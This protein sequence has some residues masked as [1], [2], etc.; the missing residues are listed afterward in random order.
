M[1]SANALRQNPRAQAEYLATSPEEG[2]VLFQVWGAEAEALGL[3]AALVE[4]HGAAAVDLNCGCPVRKVRAAGAGSRLL[5][6]PPL[7]GQLVREMRRR[8]RLP[9][10]V[11]IRLGPGPGRLNAVEVARVAE[12]EGVDWL[13]LHG[14]HAGESYGAPCRYDEIAKVVAAVRVPVVGNGDVRDG[15]SAQRMFATGVAGV[16]L[17][18]A[19]MGAP[20]VF[21]KVRAECAGERF[22]PPDLPAIGRIIMEHH[23]LLA[24]LLGSERAIRHCRKLG[25]FY[26]RGFSGAR[27]FRGRLSFCRDRAGLAG[28]VGEYFRDGAPLVNP[29]D[30]SREGRAG[31]G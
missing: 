1:I 26:S 8:T 22:V 16:M 12:A 15:E 28:L 17:G 7:L 6:N 21:A 5:E 29:Q 9:L 20:W 2:P 10:S 14:R 3:A 30:N 19:A 31:G 13:T 18:R 24:Q 23:D 25:A 27:E 11:K 4:E